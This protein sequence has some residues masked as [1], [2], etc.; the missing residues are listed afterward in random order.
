MVGKGLSLS[1]GKIVLTQ[2]SQMCLHWLAREWPFTSDASQQ[3]YGYGC[4]H[5]WRR[6][7]RL[8]AM[9]THAVGVAPL[10]VIA[11]SNSC[12]PPVCVCVCVCVHVY[13]CVCTYVKCVHEYIMCMCV[14]VFVCV[15][16]HSSQIVCA[17]T[18]QTP[19][20]SQRSPCPSLHHRRQA[21][22]FL[23]V[24]CCLCNPTTQRRA[25]SLL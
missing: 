20:Q 23:L 25:K 19:L 16:V 22:V 4:G 14:W 21:T 12:S 9:V 11:F 6:P 10:D 15:F 7:S 2:I 3:I 17:N 1:D 24:H 8:R 13:V 18:T 5:T